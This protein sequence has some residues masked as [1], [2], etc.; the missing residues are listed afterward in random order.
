M[1]RI[2]WLVIIVVLVVYEGIAIGVV[3]GKE[4][5][6][7]DIEFSEEI[8]DFGTINQGDVVTHIFKIKNT[9]ETKLVISNVRTSCGCTAAL[10]S[11]R[12]IAP[13]KSSQI[14]VHF[15]SSGYKGKV[16]KYIYVES[17]DPDEPQKRLTIKV[18]I[19]VPPKP[20]IKLEE[21]NWDFG[22][23]IQ[24]EKPTH[25]LKVKNTGERELVINQIKTSSRTTAKLISPDNILPGD[26]GK[27]E[28]SYN[29]SGQK[30]IIREFVYIY[31]NDT[32]RKTMIF[33]I[34]GYIIEPKQELTISP[35]FLDS[36]TIK[37]GEKYRAIIKLKNWGNKK[38]K[39]VKL[40]SSSKWIMANPSSVEIGAGE[41]AKVSIELIPRKKTEQVKEYLY[42]T[43]AI[44]LEGI[45]EER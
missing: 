13:G 43:I 45:I 24:G 33:P 40:D 14:K 9:G 30:G 38:I 1:R 2:S 11:S 4:I 7:P 26:E 29:S 34:T 12:E 15:N 23:I 17:N 10:I 27:I 3:R 39:I 42:I 19:N 32:A 36:G 28:I 22:L 31:S 35:I 16:T 21:N 44:P 8:W 25:I 6:P 5:L 18:N 37:Q 20:T 41:E